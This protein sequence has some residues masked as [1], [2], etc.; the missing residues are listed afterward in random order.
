MRFLAPP[1]QRFLKLTLLKTELWVYS[2][3]KSK[4]RSA[5]YAPLGRGEKKT[6]PPPEARKKLW[7]W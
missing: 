6:T 7:L 2:A 3:D 1:H 4:N 5:R